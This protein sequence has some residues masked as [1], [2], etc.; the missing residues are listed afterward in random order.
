MVTEEF[1]EYVQEDAL[2]VE[3]WGHRSSGFGNDFERWAEV[4]RRIE[5]HERWAEV[6]RRIELHVDIK[7][8][9]DMGQYVSVEVHPSNDVLT[10]GIYQL[11]QVSTRNCYSM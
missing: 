8:M 9:N 2:S 5:L 1:I 4:T 10:G 6:T 11:K 7:E 3:V